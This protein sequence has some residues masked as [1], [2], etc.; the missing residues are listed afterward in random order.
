MPI[1]PNTSFDSSNKIW[2]VINICILR[3]AIDGY[4]KGYYKK[5]FVCGSGVVSDIGGNN[6]KCNVCDT[7]YG[8]QTCRKCNREF[9]Y[10]K[11]EFYDPGKLDTKKMYYERIRDIDMYLSAFYITPVCE[12]QIKDYIPHC[13]NCGE[14]VQGEC[15]LDVDNEERLA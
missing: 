1:D 15:E 2:K 5:C 12:K 14:H 3:D 7:L 11:K 9:K 4:L 6:Y 10:S 8:K 13:P